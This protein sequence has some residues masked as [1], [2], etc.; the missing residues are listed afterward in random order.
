MT[1]FDLLRGLTENT[2][3]TPRMHRQ[4]AAYE[5]YHALERARELAEE[6]NSPDQAEEPK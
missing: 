5:Q 3:Y 2:K 1:E 6:Q 4:A